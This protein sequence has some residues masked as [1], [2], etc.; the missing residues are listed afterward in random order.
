VPKISRFLSRHAAA[1]L[2]IRV[3]YYLGMLRVRQ[4]HA[5]PISRIRN[6]SADVKGE[7]IRETCESEHETSS[8][9]FSFLPR[10][11]AREKAKRVPSI[12]FACFLSVLLMNKFPEKKSLVAGFSSGINHNASIRSSSAAVEFYFLICLPRTAA[13]IYDNKET[14]LA[15]SLREICRFTPL[16]RIIENPESPILFLSIIENAVA[17]SRRRNIS[18]SARLFMNLSLWISLYVLWFN[19]RRTRS[20][21]A[22]VFGWSVCIISF[23]STVLFIFPVPLSHDDTY[24]TASSSLRN[25]FLL[26]VYSF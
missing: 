22:N 4:H 23:K 15:L 13:C 25:S 17:T 7:R 5:R 26:M 1:D 11:H 20:F 24:N 18:L 10:C 2:S 19:V 21:P 6:K 9:Q 8:L 3:F 12:H 16:T 14:K